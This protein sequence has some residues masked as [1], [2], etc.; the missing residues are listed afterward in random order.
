MPANPRRNR[1]VSNV[2][3]ITSFFQKKSKP[4][5]IKNIALQVIWKLQKN[6]DSHDDSPPDPSESILSTD[7]CTATTADVECESENS[8]V[9]DPAASVS[10][11]NSDY[12]QSSSA[13]EC[14]PLECDIGKLQAS[15][16][17]IKGISRDDMYWT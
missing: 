6:V 1:Q 14:Y 10:H 16:V 17:D 8:E 13:Q 9:D 5:N 3:L 15:G 7:V 2:R 12:S 11:G 4:G